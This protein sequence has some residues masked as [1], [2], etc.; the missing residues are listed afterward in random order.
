MNCGV[1]KITIGPNAFYFGSS[2]NLT[3]R[4]QQHVNALEKNVHQNLHMQR[5]WDKHK[6]FC[7]QVLEYCSE[8]ERFDIEQKYI[9]QHFNDENNMNLSPS[10]FGGC[11]ETLTEEHRKKISVALSGRP[12]PDS[13]KEMLRYPRSEET[14]RKMSLAAQNRSSET[15]EKI[16]ANMTGR[17]VDAEMRNKIRQSVA[18][19]TWDD[20]KEIRRLWSEDCISQ[21]ELSSQFGVT[22]SHISSIVNNKTW[23][24]A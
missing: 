24:E 7:F 12:K 10:S 13:V 17:V 11:R 6:D 22:K 5:A 21:S 9:D 19:L 4:K 15:I 20:V 3:N 2:K 23:V 8:E 16:R 18:R 1:Y 14:R